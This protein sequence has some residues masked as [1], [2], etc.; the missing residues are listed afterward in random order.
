MCVW[1]LCNPYAIEVLMLL[2]HT[3]VVLV[4]GLPTAE[5][6]SCHHASLL[7]LEE[8]EEGCVLFLEEGILCHASVPAYSCLS[9]TCKCVS[10][11]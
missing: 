3:L 2:Y 9:A 4:G 11:P 10:L 6:N 5:E 8:E 1:H 7:L